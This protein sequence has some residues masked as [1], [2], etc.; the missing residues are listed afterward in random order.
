[1]ALPTLVTLS[2]FATTDRQII[3]IVEGLY[4][5]KPGNDLLETY[6]AFVAASD[7]PT[8]TQALVDAHP[9]AADSAALAATAAANFGVTT[10]TTSAANVTLAIDFLIAQFASKG[11]AETIKKVAL[12]WSRPD[13]DPVNPIWKDSADAFKATTLASLEYSTDTDN[14][15]P[16]AGGNIGDTFVLTTGIDSLTGGDAIDSFVAIQSATAATETWSVTDTLD[17][18][19]GTDT[20]TLTSEEGA[21]VNAGTVTNVENMVYRATVAGGDL[22][23]ANFTSVSNI[24]MDRTVGATDLAGVATTDTV[25]FLDSLASMDTTVTYAAVTATDDSATL[26]LNGVTA[27]SDIALAG[28]V[29]TITIATTGAASTV[30]DLVLDAQTTTL[31]IS[32]DEA[33]TVATTLT[34]TGVTA[35]N[36]TGDSLVTLTPALDNATV[37]VDASAM[38]AGGL[39]ATLG[40]S[41]AIAVTGGAGDDTITT[42]AIL[43]T[44][45]V[46]AGAGTDTLV[47]G[48][49]VGHANSAALGAKYTNFETLSVNGTISAAN[50]AG[51]TAVTL[52]GATNAISGLNATQAAAINASVD[53]G[54]TTLALTTATGTS[55][56]A[57]VTFGTGLTT[58]EA[59][60]AGALTVTGFETLNIATNAGVNAVAADKTTTIASFVGATLNNV[61]MTGSAVDLT[62][63]ATTVAAT[64]DASALTGNGATTSLGLTIAGSLITGSTVTGSAVVDTATVGAG[65][66]TYNLGAGNDVAIGTQ[67]VIAATTVDFG[68]GTTDTLRIIDAAATTATTTIDDNTFKTISNTDV[69]NFSGAVAGDFLWTLGGYANA[70]AAANDGVIV[71]T[72]ADFASAVTGDIVTIDASGLSGTNA[73]SLTLTNTVGVAGANTGTHTYTGSAG[74][75]TFALTYDSDNANAQN[76]ITVNGGAGNDTITLTEGTTAAGTRNLNGDAGD[77]TITGSAGVDLITGGTGQ[78][79][80]TGGADADIFHVASGSSGIT[81]ATAD[82]ITDFVTTV[83]DLD[84]G[85][86][87]SYTEFLGTAQTEATFLV[88]AAAAFDGTGTDA[89]VSVN[90]AGSGDAWVLVD[91]DADGTVSANDTFIVLTGIDTLAEI[92]TGDII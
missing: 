62:N 26:T 57:T 8:F 30:A 87:G 67:A 25:T 15:D 79:T 88:A 75:D 78:D 56:V 41:A 84:V 54:A 61:V 43:T 81:L 7:I 36:V 69:V 71:V 22:D 13:T 65:G 45:S 4:G 52:T 73:I 3:S 66:S 85:T 86:A 59:T 49:N 42:G 34:T 70:T 74:N 53:I 40:T 90:A 28:D 58:T 14:S 5:E 16:E 63:A 20:F 35:L 38:T 55:D 24:T 33:L 89:Y 64:F 77:D 48:T 37:A 50:I 10:A 9:S 6:K 72:A 68:A 83:D 44:G 21:A 17:G 91:M 11:I 80:M 27:A 60:D 23:L 46:N 12:N 32:A 19:G 29:E 31:N 1:M 76:V 82:T 2:D 51:L 92:I 39:V 18:A 47:L